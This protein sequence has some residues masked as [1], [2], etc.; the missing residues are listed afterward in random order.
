MLRVAS[1]CGPHARWVHGRQEAWMHLGCCFFR[2]CSVCWGILSESIIS[3]DLLETVSAFSSVR[4]RH[5]LPAVQLC[6]LQRLAQEV[7]EQLDNGWESW[8]LPFFEA[9]VPPSDSQLLRFL[10][11]TRF[12]S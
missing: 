8:Q 2:L 9:Y 4:L 1:D 6:F 10:V 5:F 11:S 7:A 3:Q 12:K